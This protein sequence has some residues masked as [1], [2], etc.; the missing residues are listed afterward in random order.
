MGRKAKLLAPDKAVD[1]RR[2]G[3]EGQSRW[4]KTAIVTMAYDPRF[5]VFFGSGSPAE[6][7][8]GDG[9]ADPQGMFMAAVGAGPV[10]RL[11]GK[12]D[13]GTDVFPAAEASLIDGDIAFRRHAGGHTDGPNW[14]AFL[15][16]AGRYCKSPGLKAAASAATSPN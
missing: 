13:L 14:P 2:V 1:A 8:A 11:L 12:R 15:S 7:F 16:F 3:R 5:A 10:Y 4:G 9:F 6:S